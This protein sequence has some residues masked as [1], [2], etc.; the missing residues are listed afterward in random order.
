MENPGS[1][2][3]SGCLD[4]IL[5]NFTSIELHISRMNSSATPRPSKTKLIVG[6]VLGG[7]AGIA[8]GNYMGINLLIPALALFAIWYVGGK[9]LRPAQPAYL[10]ACAIQGA[11]GA[12]VL[13]GMAILGAW[14]ANLVDVAVLGFGVTWLWFAPSI[15]PVVL[16]TL[17]Q[18][19]ALFFN[20]E[21]I[22]QHPVGSAEHR[23]LSLHIGLRVAALGTMWWAYVRTR[24]KPSEA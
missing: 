8:A 3:D 5:Y 1:Q 4:F 10:P 19:V 21:A 24:G 14:G 17:F 16:L 22:F 20:G 2:G 7:A 9:H 13:V 6:Q 11:H 15:W 18:A 23:A 12:W